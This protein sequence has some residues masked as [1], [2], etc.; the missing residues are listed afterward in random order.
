MIYISLP[1]F[2]GNYKINEGLISLSNI[3]R[4]WFKLPVTFSSV[5]GN[6]PYCYFNGGYNFNIGDGAYYDDFE[7]CSKKISVPIRLNLANI[8]LTCSDFTNAMMNLILTENENG[9]NL[10]ELNNLDLY[11]YISD[12]YPYYKFIFSKEAGIEYAFTSDFVNTLI[13]SNKFKYIGIPESQTKDFTVLNGIKDKKSIIV[14]LNSSCNLNCN[15]YN[16][17]KIDAHNTQ[18]NYYEKCL[19]NTCSKFSD[20]SKTMIVSFD[21]IVNKYVSIGVNHFDLSQTCDGIG[22]ASI[23]CKN[24]IKDEYS[25]DSFKFVTNFNGGVK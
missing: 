4:D 1:N 2:F 15:K 20:Y 22:V 21:E 7:Q 14:S 19:F 16:T 8:N 12:R 5:T 13:D 18:Y 25:L 23:I 9:S 6:F 17:C 11:E 24:F 10:I 3:H